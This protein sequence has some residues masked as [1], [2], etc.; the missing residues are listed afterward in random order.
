[1]LC[2]CKGQNDGQQWE[3]FLYSSSVLF[4]MTIDENG[5]KVNYIVLCNRNFAQQKSDALCPSFSQEPVLCPIDILYVPAIDNNIGALKKL[6][7]DSNFP[8]EDCSEDCLTATIMPKGL[9][10]L[11][12]FYFFF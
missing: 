5:R 9:M 1:M 12:F 4:C 11:L 6:C 7:F 8:G 3:T 2:Y 10:T